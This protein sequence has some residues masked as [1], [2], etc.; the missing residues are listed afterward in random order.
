MKESLFEFSNPNIYGFQII[1]NPKFDIEQEDDTFKYLEL[2]STIHKSEKKK[3]EANVSIDLTNEN[4]FSGES[5]DN[6]D[7]KNVKFMISVSAVASFRW[8]ERLEDDLV[9]TLLKQNAV[10]L[11][12]SYVRPY[13]ATITSATDNGTF[14]LPFIDLTE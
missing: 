1:Q 4:I 8:N 2:N 13:I 12:V 7:F 14:T 9:D 11:L 6:G 5:I 3:S 10:S